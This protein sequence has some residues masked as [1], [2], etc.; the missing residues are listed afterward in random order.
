MPIISR[1]Q[2]RLPPIYMPQDPSYELRWSLAEKMKVL[3]KFTAAVGLTAAASAAHPNDRQLQLRPAFDTNQ[4][5]PIRND[6]A[7]VR[8]ATLNRYAYSGGLATEAS[9]PLGVAG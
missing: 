9:L 3:F 8:D 2:S 7:S 1:D 5:E 4:T 6:W